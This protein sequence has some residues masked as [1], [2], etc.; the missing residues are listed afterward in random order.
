MEQHGHVVPLR[1]DQV[2][3]ARHLAR[4]QPLEVAAEL[5][6]RLV[7]EQDLIERGLI[8]QFRLLS[9]AR[10][11]GIDVGERL[12]QPV[13]QG[14]P[15]P[16]QFHADLDQGRPQPGQFHADLDELPRPDLQTA[17]RRR[18]VIRPLPQ[19]FEQGR[20]LLGDMGALLEQVR[21]LGGQQ[22]PGL[23]EQGSARGRVAGHQSLVL[24]GEGDARHPADDIPHIVG[25]AAVD[26]GTVRATGVESDLIRGVRRITPVRCR[27]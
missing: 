4:I 8:G 23:V 27:L 10:H 18:C 3:P 22:H 11:G 7:E 9:L 16:G 25:G 14:R 15:Q 24:G 1:T 19:L 5:L 13:H 17:Q 26:A 21:I 2:L 6:F 12:L 20:P